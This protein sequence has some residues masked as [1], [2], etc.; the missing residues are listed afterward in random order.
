MCFM[1]IQIK[2]VDL[3]IFIYFLNKFFPIDQLEACK[4]MRV[5]TR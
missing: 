3:F 2:A 5:A 4:V 1:C